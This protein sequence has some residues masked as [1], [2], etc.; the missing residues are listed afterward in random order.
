MRSVFIL[1][2]TIDQIWGVYS[3]R[4]GADKDRSEAE[5]EMDDDNYQRLVI[6]EWELDVAWGLTVTRRG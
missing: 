4:D 5:S 6:E 2:D 1:K 3:T